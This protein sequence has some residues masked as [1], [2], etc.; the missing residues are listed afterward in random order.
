[1]GRAKNGWAN[2]GLGAGRAGPGPVDPI[3]SYFANIFDYFS[4][5]F[6]LF[7][8]Y[9]HKLLLNEGM[10]KAEEKRM[11]QN[12]TFFLKPKFY[13]LKC[14]HAEEKIKIQRVNLCALLK[15]FVG[16]LH[17]TNQIFFS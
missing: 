2:F 17:H 11:T 7:A 5:F 14:L 8:I 1:L 12:N 6:I 16:F 4:V 10:I 13:C 3:I 9:L 15:W